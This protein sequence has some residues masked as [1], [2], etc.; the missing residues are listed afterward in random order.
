MRCALL[1]AVAVAAL[2]LTAL[3]ARAQVRVVDDTSIMQLVRQFQQMQQDYEVYKGIFG[4]LLRAVDPNS[5][6]QNLIGSQPL[7]G[8]GQIGQLVT[9]GSNF[10]NLAGIAGQF[11][12]SNTA[13]TP[14]STGS[15]DFNAAY[16]ERRG[17]S[18][19]SIQAMAQQ[20]LQSI[21]THIAG[22]V[23]IQDQLSSVQ[24]V[25][26]LD[27]IKGRLQAEQANLAAQ[28]AQAQSLQTM[29]IAQE[30]Q[31][32]LQQDQMRRQ[33]ADSEVAYYSGGG[34]ADTTTPTLTAANIPTFS[35]GDR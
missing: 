9:G 11:L 7:P 23:D 28:G 34:S 20:S 29:L 31:F 14:Q 21:E 19:S 6:A 30:Q 3:P 22:L 15:D 32:A 8:V 2:T 17:N 4:S 25:G 13:Y 27:A 12:R 35:A 5:I 24:S 16:L 18:L 1:S 10:G 33:A 26:D